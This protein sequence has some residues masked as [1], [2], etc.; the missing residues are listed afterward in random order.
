M[1]LKFATPKDRE[2]F[3]SRLGD[4]SILTDF[5]HCL[6]KNTTFRHCDETVLKRF[7]LLS[8]EGKRVLMDQLS[9]H[10]NAPLKVHSYEIIPREEIMGM[11]LFVSNHYIVKENMARGF[12]LI[13]QNTIAMPQSDLVV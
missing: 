4:E 7:M 10:P 2:N 13:E 8:P 11:T 9:K 12:I 5:E 1:Q 6:P 3:I